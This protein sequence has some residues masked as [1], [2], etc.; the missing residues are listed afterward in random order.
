MNTWFEIK[1]LAPTSRKWTV[2]VYGI[3]GEGGVTAAKFAE[4]LAKIPADAEITLCISSKGG[5]VYDGLSIY[6]QIYAIRDRVVARVEGLAASMASVVMLAAREVTASENSLIMVHN[7][8]VATA[9][10]ADDLRAS[11]D[12]L[13]KVGAQ[14]LGVYE[15][16]T[17]KTRAELEAILA[18][19]EGRGTWMTA[20][21]AMSFGL[22]DRLFGALQVAA[23]DRSEA[24]AVLD[25]ERFAGAS[26]ADKGAGSAAAT[27]AGVELETL[28]EPPDDPPATPPTD[29]ERIAQLEAALA[30]ATSRLGSLIEENERHLGQ[31]NAAAELLAVAHAE[32]ATLREQLADV[33]AGRS[34][35]EIE[36]ATLRARLAELEA[37]Q[38]AAVIDMQA[39]ADLA[40]VRAARETLEADVVALRARH[41]AE[42]SASTLQFTA[43][44]AELAQRDAA[45]LQLRADSAIAAAATAG[46]LRD[47]APVRATW[48]ARYLADEAGTVALIDSLRLAPA[49][50]RGAPPVVNSSGFTAPTDDASTLARYRSM[51]PGPERTAY[52]AKYSDAL[53]RAR[54]AE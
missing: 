29:A 22:V 7:P 9:G 46:R 3:I 52:Y 50:A 14:L 4:E 48:I 6:E 21:E 2:S 36:A 45:A 28:S 24:G 19:V 32:L 33:M 43:L 8:I 49:I 16:K 44:Q 47:E 13:D 25:L 34:A 41:E 17:G 12:I 37:A 18:G 35:A 51:Q 42:I 15:Q 1:A 20:A 53:Y 38:A 26:G 27:A 39:I 11:A 10:N 54:A 5:S 40:E 30:F 31:A 23:C